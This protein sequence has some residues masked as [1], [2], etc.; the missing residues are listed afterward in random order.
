MFAARDT[1][2]PFPPTNQSL[3]TILMNLL[4]Y[5]DELLF[6]IQSVSFLTHFTIDTQCRDWT[7]MEFVYNMTAEAVETSKEI[8]TIKCSVYRLF[9]KNMLRERSS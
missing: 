2:Y 6:V 7:Q 1:V 5:G 3:H 8:L 9:A 4:Y